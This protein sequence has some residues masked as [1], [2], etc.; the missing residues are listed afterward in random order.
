M[1]PFDKEDQHPIMLYVHELESKVRALQEKDKANVKAM[2]YVIA[3]KA[4]LAMAVGFFGGAL[5]M[6][7]V[8]WLLH[9]V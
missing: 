6:L 4:P 1:K 5:V 7:G 3:T 9:V 2:A 8:V